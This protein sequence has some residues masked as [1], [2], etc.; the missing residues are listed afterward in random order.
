VEHKRQKTQSLKLEE[1]LSLPLWSENAL[2]G[3]VNVETSDTNIHDGSD[4]R[5]LP[6]S[7]FVHLAFAQE[8]FYCHYLLDGIRCFQ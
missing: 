8:T 1:W 7:P 3:G 2:F 6:S 5:L 4:S